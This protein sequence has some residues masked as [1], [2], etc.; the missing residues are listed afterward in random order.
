LFYLPS[1]G[2]F[3]PGDATPATWGVDCACENIR[4]NMLMQRE[5]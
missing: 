5:V 3:G 2:P 4:H 1:A